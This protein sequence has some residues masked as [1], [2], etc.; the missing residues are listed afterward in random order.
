M[1]LCL[2]VGRYEEEMAGSETKE[3]MRGERLGVG[4][5]GLPNKNIGHVK[6]CMEQTYTKS[7][8]LFI[9]TSGLTGHSV[10]CLTILGGAI[11]RKGKLWNSHEKM[12]A[13]I[14]GEHYKG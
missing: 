9:C 7:Y 12:G 14:K 1:R 10:I 13:L 6:Y 11:K 8:L 3:A 5:L 4:L 2:K